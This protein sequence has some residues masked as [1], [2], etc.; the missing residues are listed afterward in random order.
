MSLEDMETELFGDY[1]VKADNERQEEENSPEK[2]LKEDVASA[3]IEK[4]GYVRTELASES[5]FV[6]KSTDKKEKSPDEKYLLKK[7]G[8]KRH[9]SNISRQNMMGRRDFFYQPG[10]TLTALHW[11]DLVQ[12]KPGH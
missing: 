12:K 6:L 5:T 3:R 4:D 8:Q 1:D 2:N 10:M 11:K 9:S 7:A